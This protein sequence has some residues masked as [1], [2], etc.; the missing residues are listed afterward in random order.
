MTVKF[1]KDVNQIPVF[2]N[3]YGYAYTWKNKTSRGATVTIRDARESID[4]ITLDVKEVPALIAALEQA[5]AHA[6]AMA[7]KDAAKVTVTDE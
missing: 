1:V 2:V 4:P 6:N 3:G 5:V 7:D